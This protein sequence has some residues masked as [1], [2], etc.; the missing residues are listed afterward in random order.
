[1]K[2]IIL[3]A[4]FLLTWTGVN[5]REL[6]LFDGAVKP[7]QEWTIIYFTDEWTDKKSE[8]A[9]YGQAFQPNSLPEFNGIT[10]LTN[11]IF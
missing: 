1:M 11:G 6:P 7:N 2:T 5:A 10:T 3:V 8:W 9:V 4:I